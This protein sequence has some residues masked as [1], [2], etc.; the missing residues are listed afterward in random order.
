MDKNKI[1]RIIWNAINAHFILTDNLRLSANLKYEPNKSIAQTMAI[2]FSYQYDI[3]RSDIEVLL[4]VEPSSHDKKLE[5][6]LSIVKKAANDRQYGIKLTDSEN[7][8]QRYLM[9][10]RYIRKRLG[11]YMEIN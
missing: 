5:N 2:G 3:D 7:F 9:C 10:S 11:Y 6:F 8:F 1:R 4:C